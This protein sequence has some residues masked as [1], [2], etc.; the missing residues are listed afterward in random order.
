MAEEELSIEIAE[1]DRIKIYDMDFAEASEYEVLEKL[2][3]DS[4]SSYHED[5]S[6]CVGCL[7][8]RDRIFR[9]GRARSDQNRPNSLRNAHLRYGQS[10]GKAGPSYSA[11]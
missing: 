9:K 8:A 2:A 1:I 10:L 5:P 7:L 3:A 11:K 4:S 6:L